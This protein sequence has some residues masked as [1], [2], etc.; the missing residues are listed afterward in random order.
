M[1]AA[2]RCLLW[3]MSGGIVP[4]MTVAVPP[5][6]DVIETGSGTGLIMAVPTGWNVGGIRGGLWDST[7][8]S[9]FQPA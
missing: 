3:E 2:I 5:S 6:R 8:E 1:F 4:A 9:M 7:R